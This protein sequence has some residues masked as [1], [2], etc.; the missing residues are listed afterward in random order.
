MQVNLAG[1]TASSEPLLPNAIIS[2]YHCANDY[3]TL[4]KC[5]V[6]ILN[7][8]CVNCHV[9]R[10]AISTPVTVTRI[11]RWALVAPVTA[12]TLIDKMTERCFPLNN[13]PVSQRNLGA[14]SWGWRFLNW[15]AKI[16]KNVG[17]T[18]RHWDLS[19][20]VTVLVKLAF[21]RNQS[22]S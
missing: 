8:A 17:I 3:S 15:K 7:L 13:S 2:L 21:F 4:S 10:M 5:A 16:W 1:V 20:T 19:W 11:V 22:C 18:F 12:G 9:W 6:L 14:Y